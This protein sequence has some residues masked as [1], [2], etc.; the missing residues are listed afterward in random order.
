[1]LTERYAVYLS[2]LAERNGITANLAA[3]TFIFGVVAITAQAW[4][5]PIRPWARRAVGLLGVMIYATLCVVGIQ[6]FLGCA[7]IS[8]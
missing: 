2:Q 7:G 6:T 5:E 8:W 1:M 3:I 4:P